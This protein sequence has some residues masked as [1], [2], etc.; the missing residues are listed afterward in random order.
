[1]KLNKFAV[2][3]VAALAFS[4]VANAQD[5]NTYGA[6]GVT[7]Y[8]FETYGVDAKFG[9]NFS[10]NFGVEAQG[11]LGLTSQEEAGV[12][13][14]IDYTIGAFAVGRLPLSEQVDVFV[15]AGYH[16]TG[17]TAEANNVSASATASGYALGTGIQF[18]L[19]D[20]NG[21]RAE[22]TVLDDDGGLDTFTLSYVR[23][24]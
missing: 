18:N 13:V 8:D 12:D 17:V 16:S 22:Y 11:V 10:E 2:A 23:N 5:S 7:S 15:R 20:A 19:D 24:F 4:G 6:I 9:F 1:M 14:K 21:I 3:T